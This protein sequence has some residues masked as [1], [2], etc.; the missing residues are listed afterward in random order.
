MMGSMFKYVVLS[1]ML[2]VPTLAFSAN[3]ISTDNYQAKAQAL[4]KAGDYKAAYNL[5]EPL[6]SEHSGEVE[7][8][9]MLGLAAVES[10]QVTRGVFALERVL[11]Q[12][13]NHINARAEIAKAHFKLGEVSTSKAEF[14]S[15]RDDKPTSEISMA[16]DRYLNAV[17]KALGLTTTFGAFLDVGVGLDSNVNSATNASTVAIPIFFNLPATL[18]NGARKQSDQFLSVA[19]G[20]SVRQPVTSNTAAFGSISGSEHINNS[21]HDFDIGQLNLNVGL[22][23]KKYIDTFTLAAQYDNISVDDDRFRKSAGFTGQWQRVFDDA[24]QG[25]VY[26]QGSRISYIDNSIRDANRYILGANW[27][28]IFAG[29]RSPLL[30][31]GAYIGQED[32]RDSAADFLDQD[33]YGLRLGAQLSITPKWVAFAAGGYEKRNNDA[34]DP[35]F[36]RERQDDQYDASLGLRFTPVRTW[37]IKP[38]ISYIKNS[39]NITLNDYER[40]T[41]SINVRHDFNW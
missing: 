10:G 39:S 41:L 18:P 38:Q 8:D 37:L 21:A 17:D 4:I 16:V 31:L 19:G 28:H 12:Q 6:E 29:D 5:L 35:A 22:E 32:A 20:V 26:V 25:G 23:Y 40:A 3:D 14:T 24:N 7:F 11:A 9:Y 36:L 30:F 33:I 27:A 34:D 1:L 15:L 13:P 2:S